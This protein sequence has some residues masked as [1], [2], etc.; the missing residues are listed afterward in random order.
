MY[1]S[2]AMPPETGEAMF[3]LKNA[4]AALKRHKWRSLLTIIIAL[5]VTFGTMF[6]TAVI[7][8]SDTAYGSGYDAQ[9]PTLDLKLK[10][11]VQSTY[12]GADSSWS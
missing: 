9:Q 8:A 12:D 11:S 4:W 1:A 5:L 7:H 3:V 10:Q 2:A 6:S